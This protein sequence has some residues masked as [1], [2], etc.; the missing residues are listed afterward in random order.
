M[1]HLKR[2]NDGKKRKQNFNDDILSL[3]AE[4]TERR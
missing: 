1:N 2:K 3:L 4:N